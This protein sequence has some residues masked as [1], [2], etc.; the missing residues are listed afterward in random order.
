MRMVASA[1]L[2]VGLAIVIAAVILMPHPS[3]GVSSDRSV[4]LWIL[5]LAMMAAGL[6]TLVLIFRDKST[7]DKKPPD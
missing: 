4:F 1:I 6:L 5:S 2:F 7:N 3:S